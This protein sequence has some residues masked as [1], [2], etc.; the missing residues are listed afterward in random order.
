MNIAISIKNLTKIFGQNPGPILKKI[1]NGQSVHSRLTE[2]YL[3]A[4]NNV[5]IDIQAGQIHAIMGLSGSGKST[6]LR[7]INALIVPDIG[8]ICVDG[9]NLSSMTRQELQLMRQRHVTMVF[10]NFA[11]FPHQTVRQN[12]EF[13]AVD[14]T[15]ENIDRWI[16]RVNLSDYANYYPDQLSGG[17]QQRVGLARAL[18]TEADIILMDEAFS[19]LDPLIK[20]EMQSILLELQQE[21]H[22]TIVFITHDLD[23]A[24]EIGDTITLLKDGEIVQ[25]G[26]P[27]DILL[28]PKNKFVKD[29]IKTANQL[30][31][32]RCSSLMTNGKVNSDLFVY[33]TDKLVTASKLMIDQGIS[34]IN[35]RDHAL[36]HHLGCLDI[37]AISK[38][39]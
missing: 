16:Q 5:N 39:M 18:A 25:T 12:I 38:L 27:A 32:I 20:K 6:L 13:G 10:Q 9:C 3:I 30:Q 34:K 1:R 2:D 28:T 26:S 24:L 21:L 36:K 8:E 4:L 33:D 14:R 17:M 22:K 11:L 15:P 31:I 29:F 23:E 37:H 7:H 19:A 35:V